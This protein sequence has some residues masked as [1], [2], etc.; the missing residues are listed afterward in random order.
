MN[1]RDGVV[2][3]LLP[4][5]HSHHSCQP[6]VPVGSQSLC[7]SICN[8]ILRRTIF[9]PC[10]SI[11]NTV[12]DEMILDVDVLGTSMMLG[13]VCEGDSAL[14]VAVDEILIIDVVADLSEKAE[15]PDL[16]LEGV[17]D[18]HVFRLGGGEGDCGL[19]L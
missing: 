10:R 6:S 1:P 8:H 5:P 12:P 4:R 16:L 14:V 18:S 17:E 15:E 11:L 13:I 19:F 2:C 3:R 9:K 7:Q